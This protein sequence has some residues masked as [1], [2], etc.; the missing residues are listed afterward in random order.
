MI[1]ASPA[2]FHTRPVSVSSPVLSDTVGSILVS[3]SS[4]NVSVNV[5]P[6][7]APETSRSEISPFVPSISENTALTRVG[8]MVSSEKL[9]VLTGAAI[10][11]ALSVA[12]TLTV[13]APSESIPICILSSVIV[14]STITPVTVTLPPPSEVIMTSAVASASRPVSSTATVSDA[15]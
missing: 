4:L 9:F 1:K 7:P 2:A 3:I 11:P 6:A 10:L 12:T 15:L 13:S 8:L 14:P 5:T